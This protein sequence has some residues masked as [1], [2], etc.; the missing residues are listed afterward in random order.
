M[1]AS[2]SNAYAIASDHGPS[3]SVWHVIL[4]GEDFSFER[5][6]RVEGHGNLPNKDVIKHAHPAASQRLLLYKERGAWRR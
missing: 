3:A 2:L 5:Q 6:F 1:S 4:F